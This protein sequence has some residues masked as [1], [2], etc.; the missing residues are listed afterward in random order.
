MWGTLII[1]V[2]NR[3]DKHQISTNPT[4]LAC[5]WWENIQLLQEH[6]R[7]SGQGSLR[8]QLS[9]IYYFTIIR[10][11]A[12][13]SPHFFTA[14]ILSSFLTKQFHRR[15]PRRCFWLSFTIFSFVHPHP[16][17]RRLHGRSQASRATAVSLSG[18]RIDSG[19]VFFSWFG[20]HIIKD[21]KYFFSVFL[22]S[23][24]NWYWS[25]FICLGEFIN[26]AIWPGVFFMGRFLIVNSWIDIRIFRLAVYSWLSF[27]N[28]YFINCYSVFFLLLAL[29]LIC[30]VS[31]FYS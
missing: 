28:L 10:P 6:P 29:S 4:G 2:A 17:P 30:P 25:F 20:F 16:H 21:G 22:K 19:L 9:L 18:W 26:E 24:C 8:P 27:G 12:F 13:E 31:S 3:L 15:A 23:L 7:Q 5:R 14:D 11:S 1:F